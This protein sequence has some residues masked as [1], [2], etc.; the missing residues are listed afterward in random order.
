MNFKNTLFFYCLFGCSI[1]ALAQDNPP[2][3]TATGS[4]QYCPGESIPIA[5]SVSI[6]DPDV[7]DNT[8]DVIVIQISQG[9]NSGQDLLVLT[10]AHPSISSTWNE[11]Q[12]QLTLTGPATFTEFETAIESVTYQTSQILFL[13]EKYFSINIGNA[14]YLPSTGHYYFYVENVGISWTQAVADASATTYYGLQGYLATLTSS[15]ESQIA[16][17]QSIGT[18]WIGASDEETEGVWKWV[19]G[20]EAGTTFWIGDFTGGPANGAFS[21]WNINEPNDFGGNEDYAHITDPSIGFPGSWNDLPVLG[22]TEAGNP[23]EPKGYIVEFGGMP[24][25]PVVN[26]STSTIIYTP[27]I[28][29]FNNNSGCAN[30]P[31]ELSVTSNADNVFWFEDQ[32]STTV[33][34][35]GLTYSPTVSEITTFWVAPVFSGCNNA[36]IRS[37]VIASVIPTPQANDITISQCDDTLISDG[38]TVFNLNSYSANFAGEAIFDRQINYYL[39]AGLTQSINGNNY[40]NI[41]NPQTVFAEIIFTDNGCSDVA[42]ITLEVNSSLVN[43]VSIEACDYSIIDGITTFTLSD[44]DSDI[45]LGLPDGLNTAFFATFN[46]ALTGQNPLPNTYENTIPFNQTIYTRV[47]EDN[48][49]YGIAEVELIVNPILPIDSNEVVYYCSNQ[50]PNTITLSTQVLD[51]NYSFI[52]STGATTSAIEVNQEGAFTVEIINNNTLCSQTKVFTVLNS[53]VATI[54]S[55]NVID[56]SQN[57]SIT[58]NVSGEGTYQYALDFSGPYQMSNVFYNI[59]AGEYTV[60]I[61]DTKNDCGIVSINV[62]VL[63]YP[64]FFTPNDDNINDTW[65]IKGVPSNFQ[66]AFRVNIYDRYGKLLYTMDNP[67]DSWDGKFNGIKLPTSDY[68]FTA[69]LARGKYFTGHF[70]LKTN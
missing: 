13:N 63:G 53:D 50:F 29:S 15:Q 61:K 9:Y 2:S 20:P 24:G 18:G 66:A 36:G 14:N 38:V 10:G 47:T 6:T 7:G 26:L 59:E 48:S 22:S 4:N 60:Y 68:W 69:F 49:C 67:N 70:T 62:Y 1:A 40:T 27:R 34:S 64:N 23:Y 65:Q 52:W 58:I 28:L 19:T 5:N 56:V 45:L 30:E 43:N 57:N 16:G 35:E 17:E 31:I 46:E 11:S 39:D 32:T 8:L 51:P 25:D 44:A 33:L 21:F 3:I 42:E 55:V 37:P 41:T 54:D 12:G